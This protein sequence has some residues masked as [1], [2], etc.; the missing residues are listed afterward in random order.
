MARIQQKT[1]GIYNTRTAARLLF[2]NLYEAK[3]FDEKGEPKFGST[4]LFSPSSVDVAEI[5]A[6]CQRIAK[7]IWPATPYKDVIVPG[8][9]GEKQIERSAAAAR[10]K[11]KEPKGNEF[12]K[13]QWVVKASSKFQPALAGVESGKIVKYDTEVAKV[14]AKERFYSGANAL[15]QL[16]FIAYESEMGGRN[17]PGITCYLNMVMV[18]GG[19][20]RIGG[21]GKADADVFSQYI[22]SLSDVNPMGAEQF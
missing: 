18:T 6:L 8:I 11:G 22:G 21:S 10:K 12:Y 13:G 17:L 1:I 16:N 20:D 14:A 19:G 7:E 2:P 9:A 3:A 4:L 15:V 5:G